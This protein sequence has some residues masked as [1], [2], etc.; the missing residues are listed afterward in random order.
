MSG[1]GASSPSK[2]QAAPRAAFVT[3]AASRDIDDEPAAAHRRQAGVQ[4][5][6]AGFLDHVHRRRY[7]REGPAAL[8]WLVPPRPEL[9]ASGGV[10]HL[11]LR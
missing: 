3:H 2:M 9:L 7:A 10:D 5:F 6:K 4:L 8:P 11:L 1:K